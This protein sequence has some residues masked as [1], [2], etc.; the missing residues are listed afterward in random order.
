MMKYAVLFLILIVELIFSSTVLQFFSFLGSAP[1][2]LL[3]TIMLY[4]II[5]RGKEGLVL[6]V[7]IGVLS[8]ILYGPYLGVN[9]IAFALVAIII[10]WVS[11]KFSQQ[12]VLTSILCLVLA[13]TVYNG[14]IYFLLLIFQGAM[15]WMIY[16]RRFSPQYLI[17]NLIV[18]FILRYFILK[19]S[20]HPDFSSDL[21]V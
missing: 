3:I 15:P 8:D 13:L 17:I 19:L 2:M 16:L 5:F 18:M 20:Q 6:A 9:T 12:S 21:L 4:S 10:Y 1:E 11:S 14:L 7:T